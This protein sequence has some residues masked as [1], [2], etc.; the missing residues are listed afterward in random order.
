MPFWSIEA[1]LTGLTG[2][3]VPAPDKSISHRGALFAAL[4]A[5]TSRIENFLAG[6]D[7]L[8]TAA[9][10]RALGATVA[11]AP[12]GALT[13]TSPGLAG[14]KE[15]PDVLDCGNSGTTMRL[16]AG[17]LAGLAG[18]AV[19]TGDASLR[20]RPMGR[21]VEPLRAMGARI[22]GRDGGRLAPL[23]IRGG[24]LRGITYA[25]PLASAQV[26]SALLL[27]GLF[28]TGETL[29]SEPARSRD[30]TE[31]LLAAMGADVAVEDLTVRL[32]PGRALAPLRMRVPGDFSSAAFWVVAA[33]ILPGSDLLLTG[34]GVNPT[35]TGLLDA[36]EA[37]GADVSRLNPRDEGGE[38]VC[39]LRVRH[40]PLRA[41]RISGAL[42]PR[43]ID[44]LPVF[45]VAA[46][47][48]SG[49]SVV[50]DAQELRAKESDRIEAVVRH[51]GA[52]GLAARERP[53]GFVVTGR[54]GR[55]P[56]GETRSG[57]DHRIAMSAAIMGLASERGARVEDVACV[58]TSYPAFGADLARLTG[59]PV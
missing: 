30:H 58:E 11:L 13:V 20:R 32:R 34:V 25:S 12:D 55:Y 49:E 53:D 18:H 26:K 23:A 40:A 46:G 50:E 22:D 36:L 15:P 54:P 42:V 44:E 48:A 35:R 41:T 31:R 28:A 5:G 14:L 33:A 27:A 51:L 59:S 45:A 56:G 47:L 8:A 39:D 37:M 57:G 38:P 2:T 1:S 43:M 17:V 9:L 4:A 7:C 3:L 6:E 29:V 10:V 21:V 52:L 16:S 24:G 19:L